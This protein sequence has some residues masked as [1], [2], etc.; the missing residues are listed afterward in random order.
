MEAV[1]NV[2]HEA[3]DGWHTFTSPNLRGLFL[4]GRAKDLDQLYDCLPTAIATLI[5]CDTAGPFKV[6][7]AKPFDRPNR[8]QA[9][10]SGSDL[11]YFIIE[12]ADSA[13]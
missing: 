8:N 5:E 13:H 9:P 2:R 6:R 10:A 4:T 7:P 11:L 1:L 12:E 3:H